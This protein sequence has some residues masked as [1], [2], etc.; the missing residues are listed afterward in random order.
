[1]RSAVA[2]AFFCG[3]VPRLR[4]LQ[5]L[6][7][8]RRLQLWLLHFVGSLPLHLLDLST[9]RL[10]WGSSLSRKNPHAAIEQH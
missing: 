1:M 8:L 7:R 6:R 2:G 5:S 3:A 9:F 4:L 10:R